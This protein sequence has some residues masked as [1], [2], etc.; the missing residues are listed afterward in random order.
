MITSKQLLDFLSFL[1]E[2]RCSF[3][4]LEIQVFVQGHEFN[5]LL[6][7]VTYGN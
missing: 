2:V 6:N 1:A 3:L 7:D 4:S 5:I